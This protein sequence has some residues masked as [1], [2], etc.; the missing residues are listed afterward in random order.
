[1]GERRLVERR[2][3]SSKIVD[4]CVKF[5]IGKGAVLGRSRNHGDQPITERARATAGRDLGFMPGYGV[6]ILN[7]HKRS[8]P[9]DALWR[10]PST[11]GSNCAET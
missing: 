8:W 11:S 4:K 3:A 1:L 7:G 9:A 2:D 10:F 6:A 5:I